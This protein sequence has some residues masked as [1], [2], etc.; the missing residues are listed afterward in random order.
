MKRIP[1]EAKPLL[2]AL[3]GRHRCTVSYAASL[4]KIT[5]SQLN[6]R[7]KLPHELA[8]LATKGW[9]LT[10]SKALHLPAM[11]SGPVPMLIRNSLKT[12]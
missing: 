2:R 9:T 10:T 7:L 6:A 3:R 8:T 5:S 1:P 11:F 12:P 4:L